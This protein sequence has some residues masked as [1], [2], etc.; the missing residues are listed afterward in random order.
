[1]LPKI[2]LAAACALALANA[3]QSPN[4]SPNAY[5][6]KD[7]IY[8]D[9]AVIGGGSSGVYT[10]VRLGDNNYSTVIIEKKSRLGGHAET[11]VDPVNGF[12]IDIGVQVFDHNP[13]VINYFSRF[14][15]SLEPVG[16]TGPRKSAF[17]NMATGKVV[18]AV[19]PSNE[20]FGAALQAYSTQLAKYPYL[21]FGNGF[22]L[23][24]PVD[25]ELLEPFGSFVN[26]Y[27]LSAL[28]PETFWTNEGYAPIL[29][30]STIYMIKY[31]DSEEV[32]SFENGYLTTTNHD[33]SELYEKITNYLTNNSSKSN[34]VLFDSQIL[35]MDRSSSP[36][37]IIVSTSQGTKLILVKKLV[38]AIPP[39]IHNLKGFD[40]SADEKGLF[41]Q[42]YGNGY[43]AAVLNNT[44][45]PMDTDF[46]SYDPDAPYG[47]SKLPGVYN[48]VASPETNLTIVWYG[49]PTSELTDDYVKSDILATI[50]RVKSANG[51]SQPANA[52]Q[53]SFVDY[54]NHSPFN[55]MVS[56]K[57]IENGWYTKMN[58]LQGCRNTFWNGAFLETQ[59]SSAIWA[60]TEKN[61]VPKVV[62]SLKNE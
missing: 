58:N 30:I 10:A 47:V 8:R 50:A 4:F 3:L 55:L 43:Y 33:I 37:K 51:I 42:L 27:N 36:V 53:P 20:A 24:Y 2:S 18:D 26:K 17:T 15:V 39:T 6:P 57:A 49:S 28:F 54:S 46:E 60:W 44:G 52:P 38:S 21:G 56:N 32:S 62:N 61:L 45:L 16:A 7:V 23:Q 34:N 5:S 13:E 31:F 9:V 19:P 59:A 41:S 12:T 25:P 22:D 48:L 29:N 35:A 40:I 14:N 11:Y 1:M